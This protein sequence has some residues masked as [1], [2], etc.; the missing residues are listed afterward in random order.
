MVDKPKTDTV[1]KFVEDGKPVFAECTLDVAQGDTMMDGFRPA[2][3]GLS[4]SYSNF[5]EVHDFDFAMSLKEGDKKD[6][7]QY[8]PDVMAAGALARSG[9]GGGVKQMGK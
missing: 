5:F 7:Q 9:G 3:P 2:Q 8:P 1:M 6:D 4:T